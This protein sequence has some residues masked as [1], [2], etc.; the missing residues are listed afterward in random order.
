MGVIADIH[1]RYDVDL[2]VNL[3]EGSEDKDIVEAARSEGVSQA[4]G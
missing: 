1:S 2:V 4:W 3:G